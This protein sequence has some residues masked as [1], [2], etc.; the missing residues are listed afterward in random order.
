MDVVARWRQFE[1][2]L[3]ERGLDWALR[4]APAQ[5]RYARD[6]EHP[7][8][9]ELEHL[10]P[11]DY[12]TFAAEIGY[13]VLSYDPD[14]EGLSFLPPEAMAVQ[15]V[16]QCDPDLVFPRPVPGRPTRC[17]QAFFAG[18]D[19]LDYQGYS[20]G[21]AA[22][23][24]EI[25]V[26]IVEDGG[27]VEAVGTFTEWLTAELGEHEQRIC[28][29]DQSTVTNPPTARADPH[30]LLAHSLGGSYDQD[31]YSAADLDL[32]WVKGD[33]G[34]YGLIS[35]TGSWLLPLSDRFRAVRPFRDGVA[36]VI[37]RVDGASHLGEWIKIQPDGSVIVD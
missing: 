1:R 30:D 34:S 19:L 26:W 20:F 36:E 31:P 35:R 10:L 12:R 32:C 15:S 13:P 18:F 14:R 21:P 23:G 17:L 33:R 2:L 7:H 29:R 3:G 5:L 9:A 16:N 37:L 8:G 28:E 25:A 6:A 4:S 11:A 22:G 27:P 24:D